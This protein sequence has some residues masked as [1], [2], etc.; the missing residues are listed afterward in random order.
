MQPVFRGV[1]QKCRVTRNTRGDE[2]RRPTDVERSIGERNQL[3]EGP[4]RVFGRCGHGWD[5]RDECRVESE[6]HRRGTPA[7]R[8]DQT[9]E[10]GGP[11]IVGVT[12]ER[13]RQLEHFVAHRR[14][15][16]C[17][18]AVALHMSHQCTR[19]THTAGKPEA[20]THRDVRAHPDRSVSPA[21]EERDRGRM[22]AFGDVCS[23]RGFTDT[24]I[25]VQA[26]G[27]PERVESGAQIG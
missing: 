22:T 16:E 8:D 26:H 17:G 3:R 9:A 20:A 2:Q 24:D 21:A 18:F 23:R 1:A 15:R 27:Q 25:G 6:W 5:P 13:T 10:Q 19:D 7:G 12:L 14:R 4:T 11:D